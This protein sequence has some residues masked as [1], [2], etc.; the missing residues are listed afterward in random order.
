MPLALIFFHPPEGLVV[1]PVGVSL[2][3][4]GVE[5]MQGGVGAWGPFLR[6]FSLELTPPSSLAAA[7]GSVSGMAASSHTVD[8]TWLYPER[9]LVS[10]AVQ[11]NGARSTLLHRKPLLVPGNQMVSPMGGHWNPPDAILDQA[12]GARSEGSHVR[13]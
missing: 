13:G 7:K 9:E 11:R 2:S 5:E 8:T 10:Y 1:I 3:G 4:A 6:K 12:R